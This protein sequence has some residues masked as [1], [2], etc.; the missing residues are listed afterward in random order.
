MG[1]SYK[2]PGPNN[3]LLA[4]E[5]EGMREVRLKY[6]EAITE[7]RKKGPIVYMD[8]SYVNDR[9]Q[10]RMCWMKSDSKVIK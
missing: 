2:S 9:H 8:E 10:S 6:L 7:A 1:Y 5:T 4:I 3:T